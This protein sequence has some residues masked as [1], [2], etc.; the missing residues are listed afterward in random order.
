M[1]PTVNRCIT[2]KEAD[3][4][5]KKNYFTKAVFTFRIT[6]K[7]FTF[8]LIVNKYYLQCD[9]LYNIHYLYNG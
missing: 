8:S 3:S 2:E 7:L 4:M 1:L 9:P 5:K 6:H